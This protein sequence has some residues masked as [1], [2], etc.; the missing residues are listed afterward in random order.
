MATVE[1]IAR[2][3]EQAD[4]A[5]SKR[6]SAAARRVGELAVQRADAATKLADIERELG[7]V[8]AE[9][10]DVIGVD[11][12]AEFT[13]VPAADLQQWLNGRVTTRPKRKRSTATVKRDESPAPST[14]NTTSANQP[15]AQ[16][17]VAPELAGPR[18]GATDTA[19][20]I[21]TGDMTPL[22][23]VAIAEP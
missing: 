2:R 1:E 14:S 19:T 17:S 21:P 5:R 7:E 4:A 11:E 20:R 9:F 12:L 8:L 13:E 15:A 6:R 23:A 16:P 22:S 10:S 3:V 18:N